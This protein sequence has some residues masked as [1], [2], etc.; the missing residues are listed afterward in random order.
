LAT[1]PPWVS[2]RLH[3]LEGMMEYGIDLEAVP[4]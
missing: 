4:A 1:E 2:W 3:Q